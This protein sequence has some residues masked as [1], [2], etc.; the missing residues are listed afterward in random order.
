MQNHNWIGEWQK[1]DATQHKRVCA[2]TEVEYAEHNWNSG[3][4]TTPATHLELGVKTFTCTDCGETKTEDVAKLT[5]HTYGEW[6]QH[7]DTQ[8]KR[9]CAC[10]DIEYAN[11]DWDG[12]VIT[13]PATHLALG[14]KTYT[15]SDCGETKTEDVAKLT[16]HTYGE[17]QTHNAEQHKREC[18]CE[19]VEYAEHHWDGGTVTKKATHLEKGQIVFT[20][21]DCGYQKTST[22][23]KVAAHT[24]S[25]WVTVEEATTDAAGLRE[26][27]CECGHTVSEKIPQLESNAGVIVA[28]VGGGTVA[29]GGGGFCAW[30]F[31]F[32]KKRLL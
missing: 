9:E 8:H 21:S 7:D 13:T 24:Y 27:S 17:W 2:C 18:A 4:V 20:C 19:D 14:V 25:A 16:A 31:I 6:Q 11:H 30:W 10:G 23:S 1:H 32:K 15:C 26:K 5:A 22:T 3:V 29:L 28:A 12:G